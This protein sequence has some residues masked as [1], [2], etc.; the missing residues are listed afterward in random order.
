MQENSALIITSISGPNPALAAYAEGCRDNGCDFIVIGDVS[1]PV[2]FVLD[3]CDFWDI[4]RQRTLPM[5][6]VETL[7]ERHYARKN[8]GYLIAIQKG[9][10]IIVETDDDNFPYPVFLGRSVSRSLGP[11]SGK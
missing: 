7:P 9:A 10:E 5:H 11:P 3:G 6:L 4:E 2:D 1:S 8:L